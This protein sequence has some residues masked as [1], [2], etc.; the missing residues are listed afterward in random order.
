M[1]LYSTAGTVAATCNLILDRAA[2]IEDLEALVL[3]HEDAEIVDGEFGEKLRRAFAD[4]TVGIAGC[5]GA[6]AAHGIAWWDPSLTW[7]SARYRYEE[8]G[9]GELRWPGRDEAI[10]WEPGSVDTVYGVL[11]AFSPWA[12]RNLRFDES[13]GSI[14]GYDFDICAQARAAGK[15][16]LAVDLDVVHHHAL[17]ILAEE[18]L[19]AAAHIHAAEKWDHVELSD[20]EWRVRA[21]VAEA[22]A[23]AAR[24]LAASTLLQVDATE[25]YLD[26][27]LDEI[28]A[29]R[30]WRWTEPLRR[31]NALARRARTRL[32]ARRPGSS[33]KTAIR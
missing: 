33:G 14:Y 17:Q 11:L 16:V 6:R 27:R 28:R 22:D 20:A 2:A 15:K 10:E 12:V 1:F 3:V 32:I 21:R 5:V 24:L 9:G 29:S 31:G 25:T 19:F 30:S 26:R 8:L 18:G 13:F 4:E 23:G 7:S